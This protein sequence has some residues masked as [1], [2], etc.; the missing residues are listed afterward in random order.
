MRDIENVKKTSYGSAHSKIDPWPRLGSSDDYFE[1]KKALQQ[2]VWLRISV[3]YDD[4]FLNL[5]KTCKQL[6]KIF[7]KFK[8][9]I[10][11]YVF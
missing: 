7:K 6:L 8:F 10:V 11:I 4:E 1:T 9:F 2:G 3:G 5:K